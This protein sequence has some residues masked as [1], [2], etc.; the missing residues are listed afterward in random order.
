M[1]QE[2][3]DKG[4]RRFLTG[5]ATVVGGTGAAFV[6][7]PFLSYWQPSARTKAAGAPIETNVSKLEPGQLITISWRGKPI[8]VFRR[9]KDE[10]DKLPKLNGRLRDPQSKVAS[11]QPPYAAN[12]TRSIRP[13][14][15]VLIG[16]CT[17]LGCIPLYKPEVGSVDADWPG[18]F[19]CPCH[20][21]KYDLAGRVF[22]GV[23]APMNLEVPPYWFPS[24]NVV[25]I[26]EHKEG[27]A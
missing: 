1:K 25:T 8:W 27:S 26:G 23:P 21:S 13:E 9:T 20:G 3:A 22:T 16:I 24:E 7:V 5:A 15:G 14:V 10:L 4:R 12:A 19:F 11:Q 18:G 2:G 17:H 6:A